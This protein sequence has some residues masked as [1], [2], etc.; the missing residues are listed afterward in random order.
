[1]RNA[2]E[3]I[4]GSSTNRLGF[5]KQHQIKKYDSTW[6]QAA[7]MEIFDDGRDYIYTIVP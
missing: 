6:T 5:N 1:M 2:L 4:M 7:I 3:K